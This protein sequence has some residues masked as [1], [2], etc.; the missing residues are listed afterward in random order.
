MV[1][2]FINECKLQNLTY[3]MH[4]LIVLTPAQSL[5]AI[6]DLQTIRSLLEKEP[7]KI[8]DMSGQTMYSEQDILNCVKSQSN[9]LNPVS[10]ANSCGD[11]DDVIYF[12][13]YL[14]SSIKLL[15]QAAD[16]EQ[17]VVFAQTT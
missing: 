7:K 10:A 17:C 11:G 15:Q 4:T 12:I 1:E 3:F 8:I 13:E 9:D 6:K 2:K 14:N 5:L 16:T